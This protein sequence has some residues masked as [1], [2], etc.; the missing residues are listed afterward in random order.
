MN[1]S[2]ITDFGCPFNC[3]FCIT[4]SQRTKKS[5]S[6]TKKRVDEIKDLILDNPIDRV[7]LSGGGD[8]LF[9]HSKEIESFI[10]NI[11][12]FCKAIDTEVHVHTNLNKP[13]EIVSHFDKV[14]I[15]I[16]ESNYLDKYENWKDIKRKRFVHVSDGTDLD[17]IRKMT[18]A[19][20]SN[21]QFTVKQMDNYPDELFTEIKTVLAD[22][23]RFM[24]L[25]SGDYNLYYVLNEGKTYNRFKN[26]K[27]KRN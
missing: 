13:S 22:E 23:D 12:N 15:S 20:P 27:F 9:T 6:I 19:C 1:F 18:N 26:I 2:I 4:N 24:F 11:I 7:S 16:N 21:S 8:P 14:V 3:S 5:F 10:M 17:L 25:A